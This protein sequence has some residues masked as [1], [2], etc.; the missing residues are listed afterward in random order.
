LTLQD[1]FEEAFA[2]NV[3]SDEKARFPISDTSEAELAL[4]YRFSREKRL[5]RIS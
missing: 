3:A 5:I 1:R 4:K 2:V